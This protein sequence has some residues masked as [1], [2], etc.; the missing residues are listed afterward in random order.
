MLTKLRTKG[1]LSE[2]KYREQT[3]EQNRKIQK[4]QKELQRLTRADDENDQL[5]QI[6]ILIGA[7]EKR[8]HMMVS[9]EPETFDTLIQKIIASG[10]DKLEFQLIGGLNLTEEMYVL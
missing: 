9:F 7:F 4:L 3:A 6:E 8:E 10:Q 1:F 2:A 5:K